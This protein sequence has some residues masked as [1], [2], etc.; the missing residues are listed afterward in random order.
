MNVFIATVAKK[1][2]CFACLVYKLTFSGVTGTN[3]L[4]GS[5][6]EVGQEGMT[7]SL[8]WSSSSSTEMLSPD[9][10]TIEIHCNTI[11]RFFSG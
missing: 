6:G 9:N 10:R 7:V 11:Q 5:D 2:P 3:S 1:V 8:L 4:S